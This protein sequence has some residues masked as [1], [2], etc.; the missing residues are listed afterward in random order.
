MKFQYASNLFIHRMGGASPIAPVAPILVLA[1]GTGPLSNIRVQTFYHWCSR[2]YNRVYT[3]VEPQDV[4][5][6]IL[7]NIYTLNDRSHRIPGGLRISG[8][9]FDDNADILVSD[10]NF[11]DSEKLRVRVYSTGVFNFELDNVVQVSNSLQHR[12]FHPAA[13]LELR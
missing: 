4:G 2:N 12:R 5:Q 8:D 9:T 6:K 7:P 11:G 13:V 10:H 1:G 3:L